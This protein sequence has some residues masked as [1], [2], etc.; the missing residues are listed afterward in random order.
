MFSYSY[1]SF[2]VHLMYYH[3]RIEYLDNFDNSNCKASAIL[4]C[5]SI[6]YLQHDFHIYTS[7]VKMFLSH[8]F[9]KEHIDQV[10]STVIQ[11]DLFRLFHSLLFITFKCY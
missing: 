3:Y 5:S 2:L 9:R 6:L 11:E 7:Q 1:F 10:Q 8:S 4:Y